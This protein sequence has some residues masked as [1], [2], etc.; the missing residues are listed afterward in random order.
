MVCF[1]VRPSLQE[2]PRNPATGLQ[3]L[4]SSRKA[5][6][7]LTLKDERNLSKTC[8]KQ[9]ALLYTLLEVDYTILQLE[10]SERPNFQSSLASLNGRP[11]LESNIGPNFQMRH[12]TLKMQKCTFY[13]LTN[14]ILNH[15]MLFKTPLSESKI[16]ITDFPIAYRL[17]FC[18]ESFL[19]CRDSNLPQLS[20]TAMWYALANLHLNQGQT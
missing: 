13:D 20:T 5:A 12:C 6:R 11:L 14:L 3:R 19:E 8:I 1:K 2:V 7:F 4:R 10:K 15:F 17:L 16:L 18:S 9:F